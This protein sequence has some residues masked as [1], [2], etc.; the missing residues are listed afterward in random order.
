MSQQQS[1]EAPKSDQ[2]DWFERIS[3]ATK[4]PA[5]EIEKFVDLAC[6]EDGLEDRSGVNDHTLAFLNQ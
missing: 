6:G 5:H 4:I 1:K 2:K 3:K